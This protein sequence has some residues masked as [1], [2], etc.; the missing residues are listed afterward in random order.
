MKRGAC[1]RE[2]VRIFLED[3][4]RRGEL[5]TVNEILMKYASCVDWKAPEARRNHGDLG[6]GFGRI[7]TAAETAAV[8]EAIRRLGNQLAIEREPELQTLVSAAF[9]A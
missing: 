8:M 7:G 1:R 5:K 6:F 2:M 4:L 3:I 9:C